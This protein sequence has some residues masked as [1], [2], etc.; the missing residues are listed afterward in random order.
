M[1]SF[2]ILFTQCP[3]MEVLDKFLASLTANKKNFLLQ[4]KHHMSFT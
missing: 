2:G 4:H 1:K 3:Y